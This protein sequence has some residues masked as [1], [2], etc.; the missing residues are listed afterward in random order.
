MDWQK[1]AYIGGI[2]LLSLVL[3]FKWNEFKDEREVLVID[4]T[5]TTISTPSEDRSNNAVATDDIP[6]APLISQESELPSAQTNPSTSLSANNIPVLQN[7][8]GIDNLS[9]QFIK[10]STSKLDVLIDLRGGDI[11]QAI[12]PLHKVKLNGEQGFTILDLT[13]NTTYISRSGLIGVNGTDTS[14]GSRPVFSSSQSSYVLDESEDS[15]SVDLLFNQNGIDITKRFIFT[16]DEYLIYV[17][18]IINNKTSS[19]WKANFYGQIKRD[20][21]EPPAAADSGFGVN[22]YLGAAT[23]REDDKYQKFSFKDLGKGSEE[24]TVEEFTVKG[25]WVAMVQHYFTSAWIPNEGEEN[26]FSLRKLSNQN[27]YL[28]GFVGPQTVVNPGE[29]GEITSRFY[30]GPKDIDHLEEIAENLDLTIDFGFLWWIAKPLFHLLDFLH[31]Y[32]GN[33]GW[34]IIVLTIIVKTI[35]FYPSAMS[36]RSMAKMRKVSPQMKDIKERCGDDKQKMSQ[37]MMK[38]YKKEKVNPMGGCLPI[39]IQMPVF[40]SLYWM[41]MESVELRHAPF[42]LWINDLSVMDPYFV[43]PLLMGA[44]MFIQQQLNPTP[45]DPMQAKIMKWMP[46]GFTFMFL[47]FPAGLVIYWVTNNTLS[48]IQQ[49][50]ITR[51]IEKAG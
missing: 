36:Y 7:N 9:T 34:S 51:N 20:D 17:N 50:I 47:W 15:L 49:Y 25:G 46:V 2:L 21:H 29:Q 37:E 43:F 16:N 5:E 38:L 39:L 10:V 11:V 30:V 41:L 26:T 8:N 44:T 31:S 19:V 42:A 23:T 18:Y 28:L 6:T 45:P 4:S 40:I 14:A 1:P 33:W 32:I 24:S 48:I 27:M 3:L 13:Q 12:L 22:P 35:F